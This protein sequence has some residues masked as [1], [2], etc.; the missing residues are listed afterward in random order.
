METTYT[1]AYPGRQFK[2]TWQRYYDKSEQKWGIK[3]EYLAT[4]RELWSSQKSVSAVNEGTSN[5]VT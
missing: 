2:C 5:L 3:L 1:D 4:Q